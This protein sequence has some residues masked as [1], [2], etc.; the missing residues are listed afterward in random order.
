M[1]IKELQDKLFDMLCVVDDICKKENVPYYLEGGTEIGAVREHD[2]IPWDDDMDIKV[3]AEDYPAFKKA[4]EENLP[5]YMHLIGPNTIV[6]RFYDYVVRIYD[7]RYMIR[8]E[9][10]EDRY[11]NNYQNYVCVDVFILSY[12]PGRYFGQHFA[13][14]ILYCLYGMGM[15][16][17]LS[18]DYQK[19]KMPQ[20]IVVCILST[21]GR[22]IPVKWLIACLFHCIALWSRK[23]RVWRIRANSPALIEL[24]RAEW[25]VGEAHMGEI[26]GRKFP[27]PNGY[28]AELR[29]RY[30]DYMTPVRNSELYMQHLR[31]E[32]F[33]N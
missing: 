15:G 23:P 24:M 30:G 22:I 17:R 14:G 16:H 19:Y 8:P 11:Y 25:Y 10:E 2:F 13:Q 33:D 7:E 9:T 20:K 3:M 31:D 1:K 29:W 27:V 32:D 21:I 28:D 12:V 26:R 6:P 4:M 18:L 5:D